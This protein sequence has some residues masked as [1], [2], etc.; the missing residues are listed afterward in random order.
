MKG[1]MTMKRE[2]ARSLLRHE[3]GREPSETEID[4]YM[5]GFEVGNELMDCL[6][7]MTVEEFLAALKHGVN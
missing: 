3:I 7:E 5:R 4:G 2:E 6:A 1:T